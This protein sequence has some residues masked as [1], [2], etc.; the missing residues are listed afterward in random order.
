PC[1]QQSFS[2]CAAGEEFDVTGTKV[3]EIESHDSGMLLWM[4]LECPVAPA[5]AI[6]PYVKSRLADK[7]VRKRCQRK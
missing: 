2:A 1:Y 5:S 7:I 4:Q 3:G 6:A